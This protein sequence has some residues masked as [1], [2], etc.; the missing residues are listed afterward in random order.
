METVDPIQ[1]VIG[2]DECLKGDTFG[3]IIVA[4]VALDGATE[5]QLKA[6]GV[7]DSK[8]ISDAAIPALAELITQH[9]LATAIHIVTPEAYNSEVG[10]KKGATTVL[11]NRLHQEVGA[12]LKAHPNVG[13]TAF[14][15]VDEYPGCTAGDHRETGA[16]SK[17]LAVA[18]ASIL[19]RKAG[20][21]Q[22]AELKKNA[23]FRV[24]KGSSK[25]SDALNSL[26]ANNLNPD[27]YV[28][29]HFKNVQAVF[30][31]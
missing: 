23:G 20:L 17:Y 25:V 3:G 8:T 27:H 14:H 12:E 22:L 9:A 15:I 7:R 19:A 10:S 21:D 16:E 6:Q 11:L 30:P 1:I 4:G 5:Q 2:S 31:L 26:K 18:A 29:R 24:P 13:S 28:K